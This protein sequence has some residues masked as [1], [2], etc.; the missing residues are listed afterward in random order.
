M[1]VMAPFQHDEDGGGYL[2]VLVV[3]FLG[4][5]LLAL[6]LLPAAFAER[7]M[8]SRR[9]RALVVLSSVVAAAAVRPFVN[10]TLFG[11]LFGETPIIDDW[12]SRV[13]S[14]VVIWVVGLSMI[15]MTVRSIELTRG[16]RARLDQAV[17]TLTHGRQRLARFESPQRSRTPTASVGSVPR[18]ARCWWACPS[19]SPPT[20]SAGCSAAGAT[21]PREASPSSRPGSW[22]RCS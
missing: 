14:N 17:A 12:P 15:A 7:R 6:A 3:G 19:P 9:G 2:S 20:S 1:T 21:P 13:L 10:E 4:W 16:T 8:R 22:P 5:A 18:S 11:I